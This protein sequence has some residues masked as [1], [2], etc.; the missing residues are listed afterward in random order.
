MELIKMKINSYLFKNH[1]EATKWLF[2]KGY[3][4]KGDKAE[5][6]WI[7]KNNKI[8]AN[9]YLINKNIKDSTIVLFENIFC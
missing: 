2:L 4:P 9:I 3:T 8:R 7:H 5:S 1:C 6:S